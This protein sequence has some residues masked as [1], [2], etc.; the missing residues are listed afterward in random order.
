MS[1]SAALAF[2]KKGSLAQS[3]LANSSPSN[4]TVVVLPRSTESRSVISKRL[5]NSAD[6]Y[7]L[8]GPRNMSQGKNSTT[9]INISKTLA[10]PISNRLKKGELK[11]GNFM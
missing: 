8:M 3:G 5:P 10:K 9:K 4:L 7:R 2:I 1:N 6:T 11:S